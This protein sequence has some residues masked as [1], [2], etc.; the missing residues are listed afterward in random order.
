MSSVTPRSHRLLIDIARA[1]IERHLDLPADTPDLL[2]DAWPEP[3]GVFVT[4]NR[5]DG[6]LRGC[7]GHVR[8]ILDSLK[9]EIEACAVA[10]A[11]RDP[12]FTPVTADELPSLSIELSILE[13]PESI[14]SIDELDPEL[15]GVIVRAGSKTGVLLPHLEGVDTVHYQVS[16]AM[17]KG[18]IAP[19]EPHSLERFRVTKIR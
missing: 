6:S 8:P 9:A 18:G 17:R 4:L 10:A 3:R 14:A 15:F 13:P 1:A 16:L 11:T 7:I 19:S 5:A 12:R 2:P